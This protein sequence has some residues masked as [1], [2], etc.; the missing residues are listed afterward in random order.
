MKSASV[1]R[2]MTFVMLIALTGCGSKKKEKP[3]R[4]STPVVDIHKSFST[5]VNQIR[6]IANAYDSDQCK[7]YFGVDLTAYNI[8]PV[9]FEVYNDTPEEV[10]FRGSYIDLD[11]LSTQEVAKALH[12][13]TLLWSGAVLGFGWQLFAPLMWYAPFMA[14]SLHQSNNE[15]NQSVAQ[16]AY[17]NSQPVLVFEPYT[18]NHFMVCAA[19]DTFKNVFGLRF[20]V[21]DQKK[22][23]SMFINLK[24]K[25]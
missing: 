5:T 13:N 9:V 23:I 21:P 19:R 11:L 24:S 2:L 22:L 10:E 17:D 14:Y 6:V 16:V 20:F 4:L 12:Y 15:I 1:F 18:R 3:L 25:N 8:Q 7:D